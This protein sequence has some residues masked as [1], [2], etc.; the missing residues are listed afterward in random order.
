MSE[1]LGDMNLRMMRLALSLPPRFRAL[2]RFFSFCRGEPNGDLDARH[3]LG[4][5]ENAEGQPRPRS[6][7]TNVSIVQCPYSHRLSASCSL[8]A[9]DFLFFQKA[10]ISFC[11]SPTRPLS[12][13]ALVRYEVC[14]VQF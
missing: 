11:T 5:H 6:Q 8:S 13:N 4:H 7:P 2:V 12:N 9:M 1:P 14:G 3:A 10:Y